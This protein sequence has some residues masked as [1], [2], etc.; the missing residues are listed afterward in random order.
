MLLWLFFLLVLRANKEKLSALQLVA[1]PS[2]SVV[3]GQ[4]VKMRCLASTMPAD[5]SW[6]WHRLGSNDTWT[7]VGRGTDLTLTKPEESGMYRCRARSERHI[8]QESV[9]SN[10]TVYIIPLPTTVGEILGI[11]A[12]LFSLLACILFLLIL[13]WLW[14]QQVSVTL[15]TTHTTAKGFS[16]PDKSPKGDLPQAEAGEVY[17]NYTHTNDAYTDLD[18]TY[19]TGGD[20]YTSLE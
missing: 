15:N 17:M 8:G 16:G 6:S 13:I 7:V 3:A 2:Y 9:S 5:V 19:L 18:P 20:V 10:H 14:R 11:A 1:T 12:S 4:T